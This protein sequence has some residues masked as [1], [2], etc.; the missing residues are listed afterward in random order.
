VAEDVRPHPGIRILDVG[1]GPAQILESLP[2]YVEYLGVEISSEY[3]EEARAR[4]GHRAR[5]VE[6]RAEN[7]DGTVPGE[8]DIILACGV[9]HHLSDAQA[10]AFALSA[11][12]LLAKDGRLITIDP[13][14]EARG[15]W[16][17]RLL[18]S[19]DRGENIRSAE[20]LTSLLGSA[21]SIEHRTD[22]WRLRVFGL[23]PVPYAHCVMSCRPL[24]RGR[25][26]TIG[27]DWRKRKSDRAC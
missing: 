17:Q 20:E 21:W 6:G 2:G 1:C 12:G 14:R 11:E 18:Q 15:P 5:F 7:L 24:R 19:L 13:C 27:G 23:L 25:V 26:G 22:R 4:Y 8:W 10:T 16:T 3:V 9:L